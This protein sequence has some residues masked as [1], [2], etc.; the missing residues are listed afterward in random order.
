MGCGLA[1][2]GGKCNYRPDNCIYENTLN[3]KIPNCSNGLHL[4]KI[5]EN[6]ECIEQREKFKCIK[7]II[8]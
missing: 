3:F 4:V 7:V 5:N 8:N 1:F 6:Y 2:K